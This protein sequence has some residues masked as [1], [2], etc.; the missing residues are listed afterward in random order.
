[1]TRILALN[2]RGHTVAQ[3]AAGGARC[4]GP[5][6]SRSC[7]TGCPICWAPRPESDRED[8]ARLWDDL[9]PDE[10][11]IYPTQLLENADLYEYWQRG[12]YTPY[13]TEELVAWWR[14]SNR[15]SQ[16]IAG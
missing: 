12:E 16:L 5:R 13:T 11:K 6:V 7:C 8:F 1:M 9:C 3:T 2:R 15:P 4:C 14:I 10:L